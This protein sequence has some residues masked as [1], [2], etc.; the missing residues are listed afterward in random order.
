MT[1]DLDLDRELLAA[2]GRRHLDVLPIRASS[3]LSAA[4]DELIDPLHPPE[5]IAIPDD[6]TAD[7][8]GVLVA[9]CARLLTASQHASTVATAM[10]CARASRELGGAVAALDRDQSRPRR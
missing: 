10:A 7:L 2:T 9:T 5:L 6:A 8:R 3:C 4:I 1:T